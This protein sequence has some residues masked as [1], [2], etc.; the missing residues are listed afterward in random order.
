MAEGR[1]RV[2]K[3]SRSEQGAYIDVYILVTYVLQAKGDELVGSCE[4]F[5]LRNIW[6][7]GK[8]IR[9]DN[10]E[11]RGSDIPQPYAFQLFQLKS[12]CN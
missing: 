9:I 4:N 7:S 11:Q 6:L 2:S 5:G 10:T 1:I 8:R 3:P 12:K